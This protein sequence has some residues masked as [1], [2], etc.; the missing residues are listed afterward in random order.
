[1]W[2]Y[3][4]PSVHISTHPLPL[5]GWCKRKG[6]VHSLKNILNI[7]G[8]IYIY[9]VLI[10]RWWGRA[11]L[12]CPISG[13]G[14][15]SQTTNRNWRQGCYQRTSRPITSLSLDHSDIP[16]NK[17]QRGNKIPIIYTFQA[18]QGHNI[19]H[20]RGPKGGR[21]CRRGYVC[22]SWNVTYGN[23]SNCGG[24]QPPPLMVYLL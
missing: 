3:I 19:S 6:A 22:T 9:K 23:Y 2:L 20:S 8:L 15:S 24:G 16:K 14:F 17:H 1:M 11:S 5:C 10:I 4:S 12:I 13:C 7:L 21:R 18:W